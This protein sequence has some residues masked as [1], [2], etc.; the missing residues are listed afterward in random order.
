MHNVTRSIDTFEELKKYIFIINRGTKG[1]II[2]KFNNNNFYHLVGL[3]KTNINM[4]LPQYIK[5][6]DKKYKYIKKH[7]KKFDNILKNQIKEKD[8][9]KL[10]VTTFVRI[11]DLL[12]NENN[13]ILYNLKEKVEG[14]LYNGDYGLMKTFEDDISCLLGLK[15]ET[16]INNI[17]N[18]A[19]QSWMASNRINRLIEYKRPIYIKSITAIPIKLY[20]QNEMT[21]I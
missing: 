10:R 6:Q 3:H 1:F 4:F 20:N 2:V 9:L 13:T 16:N 18:C 12:T 8:L 7:I 21:I 14:S 5:T 15:E 17:I 11:K 19:P